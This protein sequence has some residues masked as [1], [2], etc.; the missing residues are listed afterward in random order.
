MNKQESRKIALNNMLKAIN[1]ATVIAKKLG[2]DETRLEGIYDLDHTKYF[3]NEASES[4]LNT[5]SLIEKAIDEQ[6]ADD[7]C[8]HEWVKETHRD[9]SAEYCV[10]C[11][12]I[13]NEER[14]VKQTNKIQAWQARNYDGSFAGYLKGTTDGDRW[15]T[16]E[17]TIWC[18]GDRTYKNY[19]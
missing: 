19:W 2:I 15:L 11:N 13:R 8:D 9:Y 4:L 14:P 6:N 10:K 5:L 3:V 1:I 12:A 7:K 16:E 18:N 17:V